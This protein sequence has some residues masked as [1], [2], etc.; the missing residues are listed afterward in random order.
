MR[1][2]I[3]YSGARCACALCTGRAVWLIIENG[4]PLT[5]V[6]AVHLPTLLK[7]A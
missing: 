6:C 2:A 5:T 7:E 4:V 1:D 3:A